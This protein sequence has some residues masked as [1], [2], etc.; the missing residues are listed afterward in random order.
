MAPAG[1]E[2]DPDDSHRY[3]RT[4]VSIL[5]WQT[6]LTALPVPAATSPVLRTL[7]QNSAESGSK[8]LK[9]AV[10]KV[11]FVAV[12]Y[13]LTPGS[14]RELKEVLPAAARTLRLTI[15][16]W[17]LRDA[18]DIDSVFTAME[19]SARMDSMCARVR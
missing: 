11:A 2:C 17:E 10:P 1:E 12:F 5:S 18:D 15:Q 9:E 13:A 19:S 7:P 8:L 16:P 14:L 6:S 3:G 4:L